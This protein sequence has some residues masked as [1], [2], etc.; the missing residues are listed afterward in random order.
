MERPD[1]LVLGAGGTLGAA[2]MAGVLA[3][4][5]AETGIVFAACE[6]LVGTSAGA[7]LAADLLAGVEPRAA[8]TAANAAPAPPDEEPAGSRAS[9]VLH[10]LARARPTLASAAAPL[11]PLALSATRPIS[12][13]VRAAAL[14]RMEEPQATLDALGARIAAQGLVFDGRLRI[15][16]VE[17]DSGRRVVFGTPGA[18]AASVAD[19]VQASCSAP[20]AHRP[21]EIGGRL[22][23]DGGV[24]SPTNLD[25]APA[26]RETRVLCLAPT[27]AQLGARVRHPALRAAT[28]AALGVET[29]VLRGRGAGL[30]VVAPAPAADGEHVRALGERQGRS[31]ARGAA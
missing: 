17:R 24:W 7:M 29:L 12:S 27:A 28:R 3:G 15:V 31:L 9:T 8:G 10:A 19:A 6:Q 25:A 20:W 2:W 1:I 4:I 30:T 14:A 22:Y 21:V 26:L 16:C 11:A 23:V 5:A 13:R 18:P